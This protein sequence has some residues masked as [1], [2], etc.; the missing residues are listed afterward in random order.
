MEPEAVYES[1]ESHIAWLHERHLFYFD[2]LARF[3]QTIAIPIIECPDLMVVAY[4]KSAKT[5]GYYDRRKHRIMLLLP[6]RMLRKDDYDEVVAHEMC[7]A[8]G[9][10]INARC[11]A[12]FQWH[13]ELFYFLLNIVCEKP[14]AKRTGLST[15]D[16]N[17]GNVE[18]VMQFLQTCGVKRVRYPMKE[19]SK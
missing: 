3:C 6:L 14:K 9:V 18:A 4:C 12:K 11:N 1:V 8:F 16:W 13:G 7:H 5:G 19:V 15:G 2:V 10:H 17:A